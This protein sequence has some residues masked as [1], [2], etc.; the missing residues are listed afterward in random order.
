MRIISL[1]FLF[2]AILAGCATPYKT[3]SKGFTAFIGYDGPQSKWPTSTSALKEV[4]FAVPAYLGLPPMQY[5]VIGF[6]VSDEPMTEEQRLPSWLWSDETRLANA[7]NQARAHGAD[8]VVLTKDPA[9]TRVL[10]PEAGRDLKSYR[11][12]TN[13][14][15]VIVAIKWGDRR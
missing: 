10:K 5:K 13:F 2:V 14:E 12:L 7:C 4:D 11:L 8:A 9:L 6:I 15:G 3:K 1:S